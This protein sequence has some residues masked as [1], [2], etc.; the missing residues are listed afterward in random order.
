MKINETET[1]VTIPAIIIPE[2]T[3]VAKIQE[4]CDGCFYE[5]DCVQNYLC[6]AGNRKDKNNIIWV[7]KQT[8]YL[9][10]LK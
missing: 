4:E 7:K 3:L 6:M 2:I 1:E 8:P 9:K 5:F 10:I